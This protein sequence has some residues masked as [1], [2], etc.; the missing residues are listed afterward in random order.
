MK[1]LERMTLAEV[2]HVLGVPAPAHDVAVRGVSTDSRT[3]KEGDLFFAL[4]GPNFNGHQFVALAADKDAAAAVVSEE[5]QADLPLLRVPDVRHALGQVARARREAFHGPVIGITGSNGKTTTKE[6]ITSILRERGPVL[7]TQGNLNNEIGVPLTIM[8]LEQADTFAVIEMGAS[9]LGDIAYLAGIAHPDVGVITNAGACH[10]EGFGS[11]DGVA[12]GKGELFTA[13]SSNSTAVINADDAHAPIWYE[14]SKHCRRISFGVDDP[15]ADVSARAAQF[16]E[17]CTHFILTAHGE[18]VPVRLPVLGMHNVRNAL[19]A[20]ATALAAGATLD[21][22]KAGLESFAPAKGRQQFKSGLAGAVI[23]DDSYNAN[24]DSFR[25]GIDVLSARTGKRFVVMGDMLE[26]GEGSQ[27]SHR[28]LGAYAKRKGI[29]ALFCVG[30]ISVAA[31]EGF[32]SDARH[33]ES[34]EAL[35]AELKS[36][37]AASVTLLVKGS[38]GSRMENVVNALLAAH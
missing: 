34:Q 9:H 7:A 12:R 13:L 17:D 22:V 24:P 8:R 32:G 14:M 26:L 16:E 28:E 37:L 25:A 5:V 23:I 21:D 19:A 38:R 35:I 29:D 11:V 30:L 15:K 36:H 27:S 31:V 20:A 6:M 33:F 10:L 18:E 1:S 4:V 2:A 3:V